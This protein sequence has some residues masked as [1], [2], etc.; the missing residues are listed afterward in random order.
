MKKIT[1]IGGGISGLVAR[2]DL[3]KRFPKAEIELYEASNRLGGAVETTQAPYF[4]E[5]G[6]RTLVRRRSAHLLALIQE[7][8]LESELIL[9]SASA[10]KRYIVQG[11]SLYSLG[12]VTFRLLPALLKEWRK[13]P[14]TLDDETIASFATRR[15]GK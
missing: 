14:S 5:R 8:G 4:F 10:K 7:L 12:R 11:G 13:P 2:Y 6:P 9:S 1:I 3:S 15:F